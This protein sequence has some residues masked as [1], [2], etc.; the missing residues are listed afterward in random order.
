MRKR[1]I[2]LIALSCLLLA[3]IAYPVNALVIFSDDFEREELGSDWTVIKG[4]WTIESGELKAE[5]VDGLLTS[6]LYLADFSVE[7]R[8]KIV[9]SHV[10][11]DWVGIIGRATNPDDDA[12]NSGYLVYLREDGRIELYTYA[13]KVIASACT[14][15]DT[16]SF[17]TVRAD[18]FGSNIKVYVN[19][20]LYL[21]VVDSRYSAGYFS[22]K[23][24]VTEGRFDD[25]LVE[26]PL[27]THV[28]PEPAS[29]VISL[30]FITA[31]GTYALIRYRKPTFKRR[32]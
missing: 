10:G 13:D 22:L 16:S 32:I 11:A 31:F 1:L 23:N 4:I 7:T 24:Y 26:N 19:N 8:M 30:L 9:E 29:V 6:D 12:W 5:G 15:V 14:E 17:V 2:G 28:I 18:F 3:A 20:V 21:D 25:V 27:P